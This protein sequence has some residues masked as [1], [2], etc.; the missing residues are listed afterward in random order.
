MTR[1]RQLMR[2]LLVAVILAGYPALAQAGGGGAIEV[3][4]PGSLV[5]LATGL[6]TIGGIAWKGHRRK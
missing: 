6:V 3:P 5:L 1:T 4:E 2:G